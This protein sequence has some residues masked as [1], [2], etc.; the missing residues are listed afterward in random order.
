MMIL[1]AGTASAQPNPTA[2]Q[3]AAQKK[4][5]AAEAKKIADAGKE[6]DSKAA[7]AKATV[8]GTA[9]CDGRRPA[10]P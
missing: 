4:A 8:E 10:G 9:R 1:A 5:S 2:K 6:A 3:L 7:A